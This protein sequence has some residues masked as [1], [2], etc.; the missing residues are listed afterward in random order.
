MQNIQHTKNGDNEIL[1]SKEFTL[2]PKSKLALVQLTNHSIFINNNSSRVE[3]IQLD[4]V[5]GCH[6]LEGNKTTSSKLFICIFYYPMQKRLFQGTSRY[7]YTRSLGIEESFQSKD[8]RTTAEI[9]KKVIKLIISGRKMTKAD[10]ANL[11]ELETPTRNYLV[12]VNP[13]SGSGK[14]IRM[15]K[16]YLRKVLAEAEITHKCI[17]TEHAGHARDDVRRIALHNYDG[18][19]IVSGDGLVHEVINGLMD[20]QDRD[21]AIKMPIGIV[22]GG[23]GNALAAAIIYASFRKK[24][25]K[26][27]ELLMDSLYEIARGRSRGLA[28]MEVSQQD[29]K[30]ISFLNIGWGFVADVDI[31]SERYR[32][33]GDARFTIGCVPRVMNLRRYKGS[34]SY[35]PATH[36][37]FTSINCPLKTK[38]F[39][40]GRYRRLSENSSYNPEEISLTNK[41]IDSTNDDN[42]I[43]L[44]G[45][46][47]FVMPI[48][49]SHI[50]SD[51]YA[52]PEAKLEEPIIYLYCLRYGISKWMLIRSL[53][54]FESGKHIEIGGDFVTVVPCTAVRI[55]PFNKFGDGYMTIDGESVSYQSLQVKATKS[56]ACVMCSNSCN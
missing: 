21:E 56:Y 20:R 15:Y 14:A 37:K 50:G 36:S 54:A 3:Q 11:D 52:M 31:E 12:Y 16:S 33:F 44:D 41:D 19:V 32:L 22:P 7:R 5:I 42:W 25:T 9:W 28:L 30:F 17:Q 6:I 48:Y 8:G 40:S 4:D 45:D 39:E 51:M 13:F 2:Y 49:L 34:I 1:L 46:Y 35:I 24:K 29:R 38:S 27:K 43:T 23:S 10:I 53:L 55:D 18:I 26:P 47:V